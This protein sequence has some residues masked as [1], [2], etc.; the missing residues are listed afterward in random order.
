MRNSG[1]K[2]GVR[3]R[4]RR[5][6]IGNERVSREREKERKRERKSE[7]KIGA[8]TTFSRKGRGERNKRWGKVEGER[9]RKRKKKREAKEEE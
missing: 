3:A 4:M 1:D 9:E 5:E 6:R 2:G 7:G 8:E